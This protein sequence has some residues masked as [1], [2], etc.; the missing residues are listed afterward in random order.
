MGQHLHGAIGLYIELDVLLGIATPALNRL[1]ARPTQD[2]RARMP[3]QGGVGLLVIL[4]VQV[5]PR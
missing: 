5:A 2:H 3:A 4:G 1:L